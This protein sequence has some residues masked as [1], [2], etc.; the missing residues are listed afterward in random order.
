M[1]IW[2]RYKTEQ[3]HKIKNKTLVNSN[4]CRDMSPNN[5]QDNM[6]YCI[7][8]GKKMAGSVRNYAI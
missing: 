5:K 6:K 8:K 2:K 4:V 7:K 3:G 1:K